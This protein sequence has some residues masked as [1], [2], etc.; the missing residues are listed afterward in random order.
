MYIRKILIGILIVGILIG[1]Y[2][3]YSITQTIFKPVTSFQNKVAYVYLP[4]EATFKEVK[5]EI[6]PLLN[7]MS[8]FE[9]IAIKKGYSNQVKGGM[10]ILKKGMN[11]ND[12]VKTL[13]AP[14]VPVKVHVS[15]VNDPTILSKQI[16]IYIEASAE[17]LEN[18]M[19]DTIFLKENEL[20]FEQLYKP[21]SYTMVWNT[22]AENFR[23][24]MLTENQ[25]K[26]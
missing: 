11:S 10:Y 4:S 5:E 15:N 9:T 3:M 20:T 17:A 24:L 16:S 12:I 2:M 21:G 14:S 7:D 8:A 18:V 19:K 1:F 6:A 22:S 26:K 13:L 23:D 25:P